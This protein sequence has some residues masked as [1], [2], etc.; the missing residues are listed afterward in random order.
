VAISGVNRVSEQSTSSVVPWHIRLPISGEAS[1]GECLCALIRRPLL[2]ASV[3][4]ARQRQI[5]GGVTGLEESLWPF[6]LQ[7]SGLCPT[8]LRRRVYAMLVNSL[9]ENDLA[10]AI[11]ASRTSK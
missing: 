5:A 1:L 10:S 4:R 11:L 6:A 3:P 8:R 9:A 7:Q 2:R